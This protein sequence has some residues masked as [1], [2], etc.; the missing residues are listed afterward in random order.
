MTESNQNSSSSNKS[1]K[2]QTSSV[3]PS[4]ELCISKALQIINREI[5]KLAKL[6]EESPESLDRSDS[7]NLNDYLKSLL[8][9]SKEDREVAKSSNWQ[10]KGDEELEELAKEAIK[11]IEENKKQNEKPKQRREVKRTS[12]P[13]PGTTT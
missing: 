3:I 13:T 10:S 9:L 8:L 11:F 4:P 5:D 7:S 6:S 2:K 1:K 12:S